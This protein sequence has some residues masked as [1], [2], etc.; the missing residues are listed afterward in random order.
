[1][2]EMKKVEIDQK[3]QSNLNSLIENTWKKTSIFS[4]IKT[5]VNQKKKENTRRKK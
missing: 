3:L 2:M 4:L 5:L 1:M